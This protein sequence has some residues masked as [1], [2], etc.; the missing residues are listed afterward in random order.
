MADTSVRCVAGAATTRTVAMPAL[1]QLRRRHL[2]D[3]PEP[4]HRQ[5]VQEV[6]FTLGRHDEQAVGLAD[7]AGDLGEELG[8]GDPDGDRETDVGPHPFPQP[9]GDL[10]RRAGDLE[11]PTHIEEGLV[12]RDRLD[13]RRGV[14]EDREDVL[15]GLRV[16]LEVR[17]HDDGLGAEVARGTSTH[18]RAD[19][20]R[21]RLVTRREHDT[22]TDDHRLAP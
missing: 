10:G 22:T 13:E 1:A 19:A 6:A 11:Q 3:A 17:R 4:L 12:D 21:L 14:A 20:E 5:R 9:G 2:A 8:A 7:G 16:R 18:R 15:A